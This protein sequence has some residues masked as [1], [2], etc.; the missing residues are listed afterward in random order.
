[1]NT[2][3]NKLTNLLALNRSVFKRIHTSERDHTATGARIGHAGKMTAA[4]L[5]SQQAAEN[6]KSNKNSRPDWFQA[7]HGTD[8]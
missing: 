6:N 4:Q 7:I 2:L 3:K 1:M 5:E 8:L